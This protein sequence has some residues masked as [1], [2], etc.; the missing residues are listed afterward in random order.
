MLRPATASTRKSPSQSA[1]QEKPPRLLVTAGPN[2]LR[3]VNWTKPILVAS[4]LANI[5]FITAFS[6]R[7][8]TISSENNTHALQTAP[9]AASSAPAD[10]ATLVARV[11]ERATNGDI[12]GLVERLRSAGFPANATRAIITALVEERFLARRMALIAQTEAPPFWQPHSASPID[13]KMLAALGDLTREQNDLVR[14]LLGTDP[15]S[16]SPLMRA[17]LRRQFGNLPDEKFDQIQHLTSD[18]INI[19]LRIRADE[20][21]PRRPAARDQLAL[22]EKEKRADLEKILSPQEL[23]EHDLRSSKTSLYLRNQF[24]AFKPS[25]AEYRALFRA[26]R[27]AEETLGSIVENASQ[28]NDRRRVQAAVLERAK[29]LLTPERYAEFTRTTDFDPP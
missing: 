9:P 20:G 29:T 12:H 28:P 11:W 26:I 3:Y 19:G 5:A 15:A 1:P 14:R 23:E 17:H 22:L 24:A 10:E 13:E 2:D 21:D 7:G 16:S 8:R 25:E 4:L 27:A 18:Y 6:V